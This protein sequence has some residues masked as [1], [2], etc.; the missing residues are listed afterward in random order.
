MLRLVV[1]EA[2]LMNQNN[3]KLVMQLVLNVLE[4]LIYYAKV[5]MKVFFLKKL[6][7]HQDVLMVNIY[8]TENALLAKIIV[9]FVKLKMHAQNVKPIIY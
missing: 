5:A 1:K 7:V 8:K 6:H 2:S 3:A 4:A 9:L